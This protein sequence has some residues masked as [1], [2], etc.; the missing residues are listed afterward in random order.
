MSDPGAP[1][2]VVDDDP[3]G[4]EATALLL[5]RAGYAP[6]AFARARD[7]VDSARRAELPRLVLMDMS[8][9]GESAGEAIAAIVRA[10]PESLVIALTSFH[11]DDFVFDALRAG[12]VGYVL[13]AE[14]AEALPAALRVAVD[15][16]SPLSPG[17][18]RR[19]L[20]AFREREERFEPLSG[21]EREI[22]QCF[23]DGRSYDETARH[24]DMAVDTVRTH[25]RRLYG[26][27]RVRTRTEAVLAAVRRGLLRR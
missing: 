21:R 9:P 3:D 15:G 17:V 5:A 16:G 2:A 1:V 10:R 25:V 14:S 13:R 12:A 24:L 22:V 6:V 7:A 27:L 26:K 18:A 20:A 8:L 4:R 23:A 19:I 11:R